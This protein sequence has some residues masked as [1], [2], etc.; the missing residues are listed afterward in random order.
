MVLFHHKPLINRSGAGSS[1]VVVCFCFGFFV[2][3]FLSKD[4]EWGREGESEVLREVA[5]ARMSHCFTSS[6]AGRCHVC[7]L[8]VGS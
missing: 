4:G 7:R 3:V 8:H 5:V 6:A 2:S 1:T